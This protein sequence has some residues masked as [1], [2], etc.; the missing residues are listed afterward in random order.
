MKK[1]ELENLLLTHG[2]DPANWPAGMRASMETCL[3]S[4]ASFSRLYSD[5][6][7]LEQDMHACLRVPATPDLAARIIAASAE[8]APKTH[9]SAWPRMAWAA[10]FAC[11]LIAGGG[12]GYFAIVMPI[13]DSLSRLA[14]S[15]LFGTRS[16]I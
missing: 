2:T 8:A 5:M 13:D 3:K 7:K 9:T 10:G 1:Q 6:R 12:I 14:T 16:Y 11:A 4:S 15:A